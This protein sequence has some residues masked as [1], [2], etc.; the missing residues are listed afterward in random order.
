MQQKIKNYF[1]YWQYLGQLKF[2]L[3]MKLSL[4]VIMGAFIASGFIIYFSTKQLKQEKYN[5]IN[6]ELAVI[7]N[8]LRATLASYTT[9][10]ELI[11]EQVQQNNNVF[12]DPIT[13]TKEIMQ[14]YLRL[15][16]QED[17]TKIGF[18]DIIWQ[19]TVNNFTINKYGKIES[20]NFQP[21]IIEYLKEDSKH[22]CLTQKTNDISV[23]NLGEFYLLKGACS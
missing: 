1:K 12:L 20:L 2:N 8:E 3:A 21:T 19:D 7:N 10:L 4:V 11:E 16:N 18:T 17:K 15:E 9:M 14:I 23:F 13:S 6:K 22:V 5:F